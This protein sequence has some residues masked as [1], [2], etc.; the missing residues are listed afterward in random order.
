MSEKDFMWDNIT[1]G[2]F[3]YFFPKKTPAIFVIYYDICTS[4]VTIT[5]KCKKYR[6][7]MAILIAEYCTI[8]AHR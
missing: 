3:F 5:F 6:I 1:G 8:P 2:T 7:I 4:T